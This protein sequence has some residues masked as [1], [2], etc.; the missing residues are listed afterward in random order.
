MNNC[1]FRTFALEKQKYVVGSPASFIGHNICCLTSY[2]KTNRLLEKLSKNIRLPSAEEVNELNQKFRVFVSGSICL[3]SEK[4]SER[5]Y[6]LKNLGT[7]KTP[8]FFYKSFIFVFEQSKEVF[9]PVELKV[10][11]F[12]DN[13]VVMWIA[14][15]LLIKFD[16]RGLGLIGVVNT[17]HFIPDG[18]VLIAKRE[19]HTSVYMLGQNIQTLFE[20]TDMST[21]RIGSDK[22][23][24]IYFKEGSS[25]GRYMDVYKKRKGK[26]IMTHRV[27]VPHRG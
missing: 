7:A 2:N 1:A 27:F 12:N 5:V 21:Y 22:I 24:H 6:K 13:Y 4:S 9:I 23:I 25:G 8:A 20:L 3:L 17:L 19:R 15:N 16:S 14:D 10:V 26:Y 11:Y 18:Y